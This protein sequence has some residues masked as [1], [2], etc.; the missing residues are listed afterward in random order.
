[1]A[2]PHPCGLGVTCA[3]VSVVGKAADLIR[4]QATVPRI[5]ARTREE[6]K[7]EEHVSAKE[8]RRG[9]GE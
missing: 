1:M 6:P 8:R 4:R 3:A 7:R 9:E 5:E 2:G